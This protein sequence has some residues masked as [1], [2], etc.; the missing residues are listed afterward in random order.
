MCLQILAACSSSEEFALR[1]AGNTPGFVAGD[2]SVVQYPSSNR[3]RVQVSARAYTGEELDSA[4]LA[5]S[6][7]VVNFWYAACPPCRAE[8]KDL[9]QVYTE[10]APKGVRFFGVNIY[11][12]Q[13]VADSFAREFGVTYPSVLDAAKASVRLA[14]LSVLPPGQ[15]L[16][17]LLLIRV[18]GWQ[19]GSLVL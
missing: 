7:F 2:G 14:F 12:S 13:E 17:Q 4:K 10:F 15:F 5:G 1:Y 16:R 11:D 18:V 8:A 19:R 3:S 9:Q 6:V